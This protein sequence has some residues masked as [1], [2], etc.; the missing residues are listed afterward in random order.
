[1][2]KH[3]L[4]AE[5]AKVRFSRDKKD[6]I[7]ALVQSMEKKKY[8]QYTGGTKTIETHSLELIAELNKVKCYCALSLI[9]FLTSLT[10]V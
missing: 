3:K 4:V 5:L 2:Y 6:P 9:V 1:M 10:D 7:G 8:L